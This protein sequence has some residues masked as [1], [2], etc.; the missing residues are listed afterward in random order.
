MPQ[1]ITMRKAISFIFT[2]SFLSVTFGQTKLDSTLFL[3]KLY[4]VSHIVMNDPTLDTMILNCYQLILADKN[5]SFSSIVEKIDKK[6]PPKRKCKKQVENDLSIYDLEWV[7]SSQ[8]L[9]QE[10]KRKIKNE[11]FCLKSTKNTSQ[12]FNVFK[13]EKHSK[14]IKALNLVDKLESI[15]IIYNYAQFYYPYIIQVRP[16]FEKAFAAVVMEFQKNN[17]SDDKRY[18]EELRKFIHSFYDSHVSLS[19]SISEKEIRKHIKE[20]KKEASNTKELAQKKLFPIEVRVIDSQLIITN[21]SKKWSHE[22]VFIGQSVDSISSTTIEDIKDGLSS[23]KCFSNLSSL[24][25]DLFNKQ[26][27]L[28]SFNLD[29]LILQ[30]GNRKVVL[31]KIEMKYEEYLTLRRW[32]LSKEEELIQESNF[33]YINLANISSSNIKLAYRDAR[34][35]NKAII[36]DLREYPNNFNATIL[37]TF[38][39]NKPKK[40]ATFYTPYKKNPGIYSSRGNDQTYYYSN[41]IDFYLKALNILPNHW[42][43]FYSFRRNFKGKTVVLINERTISW[44]ETLTLILK[45]YCPN[46]TIV[47]RNSRGANGNICAVELPGGIELTFTHYL[48]EDRENKTFPKKGITPDVFVPIRFCLSNCDKY[49]PILLKG[50]EILSD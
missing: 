21:V 33:I 36:L 26:A 4:G 18:V 29:T 43:I 8:F 15:L 39:S 42:N 32:N 10:L 31:P 50:I 7:D 48:L 13:Y 20:D 11:F 34:K 40:V 30:V 45:T 38:Y 6:L 19:K 5:P 16:Q 44:G 3:S 2:A 27:Y 46:V 17:L 22:N 1:L 37:P 23:T 12:E 49:D 25:Y 47:G 28:Y 14:N 9:S 35:M 41:R 24:A